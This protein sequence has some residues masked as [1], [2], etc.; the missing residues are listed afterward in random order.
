MINIQILMHILIYT[1][2]IIFCCLDSSEVSE[3]ESEHE[4]KKKKKKKKKAKS[5]SRS[6]SNDFFETLLFVVGSAS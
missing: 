1:C 6:V 4:R 2:Y 5:R 3:S